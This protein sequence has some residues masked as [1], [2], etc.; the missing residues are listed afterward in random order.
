MELTPWFDGRVNP[1]RPGVYQ[2]LYLDGTLNDVVFCRFDGYSWFTFS[3]TPNGALVSDTKSYFQD[4]VKWRG[5][6]KKP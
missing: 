5:L 6:A 2:R 4:D 3:D 1:V